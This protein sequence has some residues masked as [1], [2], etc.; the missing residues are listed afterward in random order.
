MESKNT[1]QD[2]ENNIDLDTR[3]AM[4]FREKSFGAAPPFLQLDDSEEENEKENEQVSILEKIK[5]E[6]RSTDE[7]NMPTI[8]DTTNTDSIFKT[9]NVCDQMEIKSEKT[10]CIEDG[11]SDISSDDE[12]LEACA[13]TKP[14]TNP[15]AAGNEDDKM[16]LSSLS[17]TEDKINRKSNT[18]DT[19]SH[20][21][22]VSQVGEYYYP[23][24]TNPY[25]YTT[26]GNTSYEQYASSHDYIQP[27]VPGFPTLIP[28]GYVQ[29]EYPVKNE[30]EPSAT[31]TELIKDPTEQIVAAVIERV[32]NEL[33]HILKRD[34]NKRMIESIA[35]KRY[36]SWWDEQVQNKNKPAK[37]MM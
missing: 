22:P 36:D 5:N 35:Y 12:V 13:Q 23:P 10:K 4:M 19:A 18:L 31:V 32:K 33:K 11:A 3:I 26:G 17:S 37:N 24:N 1:E 29:S 15:T 28:G 8:S 20:K 6:I 27:Y 14:N 2:D 25:Y 7:H 34:I 30:D 9:S 16:S 21:N